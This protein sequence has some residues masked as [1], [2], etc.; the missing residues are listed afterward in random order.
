MQLLN[1]AGSAEVVHEDTDGIVP[2]G[3]NRSLFVEEGVKE[4]EFH[5]KVGRDRPAERLKVILGRIFTI[6]AI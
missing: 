3:K 1:D 6:N 2:R 4:G 5:G